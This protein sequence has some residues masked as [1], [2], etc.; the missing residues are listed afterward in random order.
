MARFGVKETVMGSSLGTYFAPP[1]K[2]VPA[3]LARQKQILLADP[4]V[5]R[6]LE[7]I[8]EPTVVLNSRRRSSGPTSRSWRCCGQHRT[9]CSDCGSAK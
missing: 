4:L 9:G 6:L 5:D 2:E 3:V 8:P 1:E 7:S